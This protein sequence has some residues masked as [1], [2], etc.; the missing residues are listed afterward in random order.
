MNVPAEHNLH[1]C[2]QLFRFLLLLLS[3]EILLRLSVTR[4]TSAVTCFTGSA[5]AAAA[6]RTDFFSDVH[7]D[8]PPPPGSSG[9][10]E[11]L[12]Q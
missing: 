9:G 4:L 8:V 12:T 10:G 2:S 7:A 6:F 11:H 3:N 5:A 1:S